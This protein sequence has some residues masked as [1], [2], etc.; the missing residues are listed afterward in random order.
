MKSKDGLSLLS[1]KFFTSLNLMLNVTIMS[2]NSYFGALTPKMTL[3]SVLSF[4]IEARF[5]QEIGLLS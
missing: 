5:T 1:I 4:A 3:V 2:S